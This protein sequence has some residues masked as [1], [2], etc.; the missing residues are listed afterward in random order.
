MSI[1]HHI[2]SI[3]SQYPDYRVVETKPNIFEIEYADTF[4][5]LAHP[6]DIELGAYR[7]N[8]QGNAFYHFKK[9]YHIMWPHLVPTWHDWTEWRAQKFCEDW[10][11]TVWAGG[12]GIG[13]SQDAGAFSL[14]FWMANCRQRT[15]LVGSTTI[16]DLDNRIFGYIKK[17]HDIPTQRGLPI[18]G[19]LYTSN[20]PKIILDKKDTIHGIF[21]VALLKGSTKNPNSS[22]TNS[23]SSNLIG[24]HPEEAFL[25]VIDEGPDVSAAFMDA[26]PNWDKTPYFKCLVLGNSNSMYDPHGLLATPLN[27]WGSISVDHD[28]EWI[29]KTGV[30]LYFDCYKSPAIYEED[31]NKK[32]LLGKFLFTEDSIERDKETY[33]DNSH[34]YWRMTRGFWPPEDVSNTIL[35][36]LT[37]DKHKAKSRAHWS[38]EELLV[39]VAALDPAFSFG[40]D[41]NILRFADVGKDVNGKW[42][43]DFGGDDYINYLKLDAGSNEP[44]DYQIVNQAQ[45]LCKQAGVQPEYVAVDVNGTGM[46]LGSIITQNWSR[47]I[48]QIDSVG[49]CSDLRVHPDKPILANEVYDRKVTELWFMMQKFIIAGQI[50]GLDAKT[51][52]QLCTRMYTWLGKKLSIEK[53]IDYKQRLGKVDSRYKSPDEADAAVYIIDL[54]R[55]RFGLIP[56][57]AAIIPNKDSGWRKYFDSKKI[58]NSDLKEENIY[59][60]GDYQ[61]ENPNPLSW[62]DGFTVE[63]DYGD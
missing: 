60:G 36:P 29:T 15:V 20:P 59:A 33:G 61:T 47:N 30:C 28:T 34:A 41:S 21:T 11:I 56:S 43:I 9:A 26:I 8:W 14:L 25:A 27:G 46:G 58:L 3:F 18:P 5:P 13:K 32:K 54:V 45:T 57:A 31:E 35:S 49:G 50:R 19:T 6:I 16:T 23:R 44:I 22:K 38:G 62:E 1:P 42:V 51:C 24:R 12:G 48:F 7:I 52:E 63:T 55:H 40:G 53:K 2:E 17:L 10:K 39:K 4:W 37:I